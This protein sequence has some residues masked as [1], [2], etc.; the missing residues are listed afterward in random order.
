M[1]SLL[2]RQLKKHLPAELA[3]DENLKNFFEAINNSYNNYEDQLN[4]SQRA[5]RI[6][7]DELFEAN[8]KLREDAENQKKIIKSLNYVVRVLKLKPFDNNDEIMRAVDLTSFIE[9]QSKEILRVNKQREDLLKH[10]ENKNGELN[11]YA[12][13]VSHD[14]K[15][16]L[17]SIDSLINWVLEDDKNV[18]ND[19]SKSHLDLIL[20]NVE[21]MDALISGILNYSTIDKAELDR[22]DVDI[23]YLVTELSEILFVPKNVTLT[24]KNNLPVI[25]GDKFRLQQLFQNLIQNAI[26]SIEKEKGFV[27]VGAVEKENYWEFYVKDNGEGIS[28]Q[29][30]N[31]IFKIFEKIDDNQNATGIGL[32]IVKRII[33]FYGGKIWLESQVSKGTTFYFTIPK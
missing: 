21:K 32:A 30:F 16:P 28:E 10:L 8:S 2:I 17:R 19:E 23:H 15:S 6:S 25:I 29:Y 22:Y 14:L 9:E 7:S 24:I 33:D 11:N 4:M 31:K 20:K 5:M 1:N 26:K 18:V 13:I 3:Q 27:E 12:H